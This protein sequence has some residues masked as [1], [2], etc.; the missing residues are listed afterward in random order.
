VELDAQDA[1]AEIDEARARVLANDAGVRRAEVGS[2]EL[3]VGC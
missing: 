1:V 3:G 2:W